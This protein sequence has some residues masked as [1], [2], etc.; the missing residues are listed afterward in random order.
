MHISEDRLR[1]LRSNNAESNKET[2]N[3]IKEALIA[4]LKDKSYDE[5]RMTDIINKSGVSRSG[6]YKNYKSKS[7]IL[8]EIYKDPIDNVIG[9]LTDSIF[10]NLELI[11]KSGKRHEESIKVFIDAGLECNFLKLMNERYEGV[12]SSFYIP[13]WNGMI[14]NA[15]MEWARAGMPGTVEQAVEQVKA[16]LRLVAESIDS[17]LTNSEQN[18]RL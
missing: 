16:G 11:F 13:L 9:I 18:Q 10:D 15:F 12:E 1:I 5:I 3:C 4:L 2:R 8:L 7:E 14:Y 6:V 17:G